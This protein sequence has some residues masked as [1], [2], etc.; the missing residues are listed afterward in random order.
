MKFPVSIRLETHFE[1]FS[2]HRDD[3]ESQV[4]TIAGIDYK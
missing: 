4:Y 1:K 3:L 2:S